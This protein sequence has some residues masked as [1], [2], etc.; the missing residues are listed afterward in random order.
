MEALESLEATGEEGCVDSKMEPL[1]QRLQK[2]EQHLHH[3][4][5]ALDSTFRRELCLLL[6]EELDDTAIKNHTFTSDSPEGV[7]DSYIEAALAS[8]RKIPF[9]NECEASDTYTKQREVGGYSYDELVTRFAN[10]AQR[11]QMR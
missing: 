4:R 7:R 10:A 5:C 2:M 8:E 3:I 6:Y 11:N 9:L 1:E